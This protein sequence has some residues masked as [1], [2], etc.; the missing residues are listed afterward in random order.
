LFVYDEM[1]LNLS[2]VAR[3]HLFDHNRLG[4]NIAF[5]IT[6]KYKI[7]AG[8]IF[9]TRLQRTA[10]TNVEENN[11]LLNFTYFFTN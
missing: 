5:N 3:N 7:E 8:Y 9:I 2:G 4:W 10:I 11:F 1:L 6:P